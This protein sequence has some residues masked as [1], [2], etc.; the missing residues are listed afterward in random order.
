MASPP[1][2][3]KF[4]AEFGGGA[5]DDELTAALSEVADAVFLQETG[6]TVT[7]KLKLAVPKGTTGGLIVSADVDAKPPK[8]SR[9]G[10][11]FVAEGGA[12]SKRDPNQPQLPGVEDPKETNTDV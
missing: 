8:S 7:L 1:K 3:S 11:F 10:F 6:G 2:F 4:L 12:L 9:A 5:L